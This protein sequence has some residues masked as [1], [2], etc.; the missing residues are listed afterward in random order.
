MH[1]ERAQESFS[2]YLERTLDRPMTVA[3]EAHLAHC[4]R[5]REEVDGLQATY[6]AL[7]AVPEVEPL[8]A[9]AWQVMQALRRE[10]MAQL[11]AGRRSGFPFLQWLRS[12]SPISV[13]MGA[14]LA[15][16]VIGGTLML[17]GP[18]YLGLD[19]R[20]WG[21]PSPGPTATPPRPVLASDK[22]TILVSYGPATPNGQAVTF[23][24]TPAA[25]LPNGQVRIAGGG[26]PYDYLAQGDFL[27]NGQLSILVTIPTSQ[28][29]AETVWVSVESAVTGKQYRSL[30]ALPLGERKV[31]PVTDVF[32]DQPLQEAV[33][34]LAPFLGQPVVVDGSLEG[35]VSVAMPE[36]PAFK[37]L[38]D[39]ALQVRATLQEENGVYRLLPQP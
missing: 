23:L 26:M 17:T 20:F 10:R 27:A 13:A 24:V 33:R 36:Q 7:D 38:Q 35:S 14:S 21:P 8:P 34:R 9:G 3:M 19:F 29:P 22:P 39:V 31:Q 6:L 2:D 12:H 32:Y 18:K 30:V 1:C 37:C 4:D 15:T 16:L 11:D 5:C 28:R 25:D